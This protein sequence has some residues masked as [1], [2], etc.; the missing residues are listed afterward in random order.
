MQ[1]TSKKIKSYENFGVNCDI[2]KGS[3]IGKELLKIL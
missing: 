2:L 3:E 1:N